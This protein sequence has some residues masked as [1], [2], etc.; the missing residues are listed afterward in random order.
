MYAEASCGG[1]FRVPQTANLRAFRVLLA[2]KLYTGAVR[3]F[4]LLFYFRCQFTDPKVMQ[5]VLLTKSEGERR[6]KKGDL[7]L[8]PC[9]CM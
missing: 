2:K 7:F 9:V 4:H 3:S 1:D 5:N 6:R 8:F